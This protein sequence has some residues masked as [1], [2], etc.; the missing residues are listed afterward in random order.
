MEDAL[1]HVTTRVHDAVGNV[2]CERRPRGGD[3][4][5]LDGAKGK[6]VAALTAAACGSED[7]TRFAYDEFGKL[8]SVEDAAGLTTYVL[9]PAR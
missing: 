8:V 9:D 5:G 2:L 1:G 6:D 3:P 7:A 4:L